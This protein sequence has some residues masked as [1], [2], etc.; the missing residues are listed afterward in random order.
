MEK[1]D[2]HGTNKKRIAAF[3]LGISIF[4]VIIK[5]AAA[6]YSNSLGIFSEALNNG[7]D[8]VTVFITFLAIRLSSRPADPDHTYGH[9][10]YEN[11]SAFIEVV[12]ITGLCIFIIYRSVL[13]LIYRDFELFLPWP[14]FLVLGVS[15]ILNTIRVILLRNASK[16]YHSFAFRAEF[17]NYSG[18][19]VSSVV[20]IGGLILARAGFSLADPIASVLVALVVIFL[21]FRLSRIV[22]RNLLDYIP[23][24]V[25]AK[26]KDAVAGIQEVKDINELKVHE[27]GGIKFINLDLSTP[28]NLYLSQAE[29]IKKNVRKRIKK[30]F[31]DS[32]IIVEIRP[33]TE[34]ENVSDNIKG[35]ALNQ[36]EIEDIHNIYIYSVGEAIDVS[37]HVKLSRDLKLGEVEAL[38]KDTEEKLKRKVKNLR[39][40]YIHAEDI[41]PQEG[42]DDVTSQSER[43]I[44]KIKGYIAPYINPDTCHNFS[45]LKKDSYYHVAFHCRLKA[46][47]KI[48]DAHKIISEVEDLIKTRMKNIENILIHVEPY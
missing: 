19:I 31:P 36:P 21:S 29:N 7:L 26:L 47:L 45:V 12:I 16:K 20:V 15:V 38:T 41:S 33:G 2:L 34:D 18:D 3:S 17:I 5:V 1:K 42:W 27:V 40:I 46:S 28:Y 48:E 8:L 32:N 10:K 39:R 30:D 14:I 37:L 13:R 6:Y 24:E 11:F 4:L 23:M 22:I 25:T 43:L 35:L 9:G 44:E